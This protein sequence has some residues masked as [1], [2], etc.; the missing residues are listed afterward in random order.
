[1]DINELK[2]YIENNEFEIN[3]DPNWNQ[4]QLLQSIEEYIDENEEPEE[5]DSETLTET[6]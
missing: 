3:I 4:S 1:M 2:I 6:E 5:F